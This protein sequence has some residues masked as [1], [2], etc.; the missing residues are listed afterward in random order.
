MRCACS[1]NQGLTDLGLLFNS[2]PGY[3]TLPLDREQV[4]DDYIK[5]RTL[6]PCVQI[7]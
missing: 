1:S 2:L 6:K 7:R 3:L 5:V 4:Y